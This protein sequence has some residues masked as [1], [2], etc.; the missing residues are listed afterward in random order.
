MLPDLKSYKAELATLPSISR[1]LTLKRIFDAHDSDLSSCYNVALVF[2]R[3]RPQERLPMRVASWS[4]K[5]GRIGKQLSTY[6][7]R[8]FH[9]VKTMQDR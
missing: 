3:S 4:R 7:I 9:Q 8:T 6:Q 2:N 5:G 1:K